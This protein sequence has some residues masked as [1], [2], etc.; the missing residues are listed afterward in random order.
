MARL[1]RWP[2]VIAGVDLGQAAVHLN[3]LAA[4]LVVV[5]SQKVSVS[6]SCWGGGEL[7]GLANLRSA[8][9]PVFD[10]VAEGQ[11][12]EHDGGHCGLRWMSSLS[13]YRR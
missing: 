7:A 12:G 13:C 2:S 8:T 5:M 3:V 9:C 11:D 4:G 10:P 6:A 1:T